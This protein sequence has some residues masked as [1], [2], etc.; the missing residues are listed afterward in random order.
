[1]I[2]TLLF[3]FVLLVTCEGSDDVNHVARKLNILMVSD[4]MFGHMAPLLPVGEELV[5]RGHNVT[6]LVIVY[7]TQQ[8]KY[9]NH[10]EKYGI[11]LWNASSENLPQLDMHLLSQNISKAFVRTMAELGEYGANLLKI[12]AKHMNSSLSRGDWDI[13]IGS[14]FMQALTSCM[15]SIHNLPFVLIGHNSVT[16]YHLYPSWP[17]PGLMQG[18]TSVNMGF[19]DRAMYIPASL[20]TQVFTYTTLHTP[21][22]A[23][24]KEYC[25]MV[26]LTKAVTDVG[27]HFPTIIRTI[28]DRI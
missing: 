22:N 6:M 20:A 4:Y 13:V 9:R 19:L 21:V 15:N 8:E 23:L 3:G 1:M 28:C 10:V 26:D 5:Q 24:N 27:I 11:H 18:A 25:P 14:D 17:W 16:S 12:M 2:A 7:E